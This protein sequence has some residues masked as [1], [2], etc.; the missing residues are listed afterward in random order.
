[1]SKYSA[2]MILNNYLFIPIN[3]YSSIRYKTSYF[4]IDR[5]FLPTFV[6]F[7]LPDPMEM[8]IINVFNDFL[9]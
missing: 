4:V 3:P 9:I 5:P 7:R 8:P 2:S 6:E 1:M